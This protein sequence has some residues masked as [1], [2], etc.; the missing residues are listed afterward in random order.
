MNLFFILAAI[1]MLGVMVMIHEC[2][3]FF[4]ARL[5]G[6]P[7][8]EFAIGF[9]PR[10]V[11][12][13]SKKHETQ[14][15]LRLI[16]AGGYC[17]FYGEDDTEGKEQQDPRCINRFA[18]WKRMITIAMG[19]VMNF[20]LA[21]IAAV[22]LF[23]AAGQDAVGRAVISDVTA[24]G[25]A[26]EA[27]ILPGDIIDQVNG[28][29]MEGVTE[30]GN[31]PAVAMISAYQ[32]GEPPIDLVLERKNAAGDSEFVFVSVTPDYS[33]AEGRP[34]IGGRGLRSVRRAGWHRAVDRGGNPA[35]RLG[36]VPAAAGDDF[37]EP[38][39]V[40]PDSHSG[41][42]RQP[43]HLPAHRGHSPQARQPENRGGGAHDGVRPADGPDAVYDLQGHPA[44]F[45][46]KQRG[47]PMSE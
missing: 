2:G 44:F 35:E 30:D 42:G 3:H 24:G 10:L 16:P 12:W 20:V 45:P 29:K 14:F 40:Q 23:A 36:N 21:F 26:A 37:G 43:D 47:N 33:K 15:F 5:T 11:S 46:M 27:G 31:L 22:I 7:V 4:A 38:G 41:A 6:I 25:P 8:K 17:M 9:G 39:A 13:K 32:A 34:L 19:P 1:V 28:Q 18:P